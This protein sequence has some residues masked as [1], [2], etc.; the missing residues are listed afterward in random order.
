L[1]RMEKGQFS[2]HPAPTDLALLLREE[3]D[4]SQM[5][6]RERQITL[7][8]DL[9]PRTLPTLQVDGGRI[10]QV[11]WNLIHNALKFTPE[12]GRVV[13]RAVH[14]A[15][16][17]LIEVEDTGVG[18]SH[19][20]QERV[21]EKF[22]QVSPGGSTSSQG[23][24]LGLTICKEIVSAHQGT[25]H[26]RSPGLGQGTTMSFTLPLTTSFPQHQSKSLAA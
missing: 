11:V 16:A 21:F 22:F 14:Q 9:A 5:E 15:E 6:A 2:I 18:L 19:E 20:T 23:L 3:V 17:V 7:K 10:R 13:V 24:G 4:K 1:A 25:I 26:A 12:E 8:L